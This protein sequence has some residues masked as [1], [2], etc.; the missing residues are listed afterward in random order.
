MSANT[1]YQSIEAEAEPELVFN[2]CR[3]DVG[4]V[5]SIAH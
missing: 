4:G 2:C 5:L 1:E 3:V